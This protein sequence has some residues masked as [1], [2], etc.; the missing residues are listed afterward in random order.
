MH[1][2]PIAR[3]LVGATA[4]ALAACGERDR[5]LREWTPAD[6][7]PPPGGAGV[8]DD[9][10]GPGAGAALFAVHCAS[11]HG[12]EGRG[13]GP[14][15]P[16]MA[17]VP[18]LTDP[19][20]AARRSDADVEVLILAGRGFMPGFESSIPRE[21]VRALALHVRTLAPPAAALPVPDDGAPEPTPPA[22]EAE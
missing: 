16:P 14:G 8:P 9:V 22:P 5:E 3:L 12:L 1:A 21:G 6:H 19:L 13:D 18:D 17:R 10:E 15:A 11:C 4:L 20:L 2:S 7:Q